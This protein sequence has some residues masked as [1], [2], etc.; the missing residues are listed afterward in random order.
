MLTLIIFAYKLLTSFIF[1]WLAY[2]HLSLTLHENIL[3][4]VKF[5]LPKLTMFNSSE[6]F[7]VGFFIT[8]V[9]HF[10]KSF[11]I[12][13]RKFATCLGP[14]WTQNFLFTNSNNFLRKTRHVYKPSITLLQVNPSWSELWGHIYFGKQTG[15]KNHKQE[16]FWNIS[17]MCLKSN[18]SRVMHLFG[19][20]TGSKMID[21]LQVQFATLEP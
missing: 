3:Q 16:F 11:W 5:F 9:K 18:R 21:L 1:L 7:E 20:E 17:N 10:K 4:Q 12:R 13:E 2:E 14:E 19:T 8:L 6:I 15:S